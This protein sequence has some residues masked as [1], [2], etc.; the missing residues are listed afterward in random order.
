MSQ[1]HDD[2]EVSEFDSAIETAADE[3]VDVISQ[4]H[5]DYQDGPTRLDADVTPVGASQGH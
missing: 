3:R 4:C 1:C 2:Y 5:D